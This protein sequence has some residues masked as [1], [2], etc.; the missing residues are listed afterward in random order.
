MSRISVRVIQTEADLLSTA[1]DLRRHNYR[2]TGG[3][4]GPAAAAAAAR[5]AQAAPATEAQ[6]IY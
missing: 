6:S 2:G 3:A 5:A 4:W 1:R